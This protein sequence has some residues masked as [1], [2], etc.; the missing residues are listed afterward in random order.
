MKKCK[1]VS[2]FSCKIEQGTLDDKVMNKKKMKNIK[3]K[4][5]FQ[6]SK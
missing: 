4:N 6:D 5:V 2:N 1:N 3:N